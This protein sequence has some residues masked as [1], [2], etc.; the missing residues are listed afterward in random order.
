MT[1]ET[2]R[3][4]R[5]QL[6]VDYQNGGGFTSYGQRQ[7]SAQ[8]LGLMNGKLQEVFDGDSAKR[9]SLLRWLWDIEDSSKE[10]DYTQVRVMLDWLIDEDASYRASHADGREK[11]VYVVKKST[12]GACYEIIA[13]YCEERGQGRLL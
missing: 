9:I 12:W 13:I 2:M 3:E 8:M 11:N 7:P 6:Q 1:E 5:F 10:L 4:V